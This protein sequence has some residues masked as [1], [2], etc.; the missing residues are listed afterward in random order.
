M[1]TMTLRW[2]LGVLI[3][4]AGAFAIVWLLGTATDPATSGTIALVVG[5]EVLLGGV[6]GYLLRSW[7][8]IAL[9]P[10]AVA[11]GVAL[12]SLIRT[13]VLVEG[14]PAEMATIVVVVLLVLLVPV[15]PGVVGGV[16]LGKRMN[17]K[18]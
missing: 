4:L 9:V 16:A 8:A 5:L 1:T 6:G 13:G 10:L 2:V 7:W 15:A 12:A 11:T 14:D 17:A 18:P 3:P